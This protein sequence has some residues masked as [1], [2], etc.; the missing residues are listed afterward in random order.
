MPPGVMQSLRANPVARGWVKVLRLLVALIFM[1]TGWLKLGGHNIRD[2]FGAAHGI[3]PVMPLFNAMFAVRPYWWFLGAGQFAGGALLLVGRTALLGSLVCTPIVANIAVLI[4]ALPFALADRV[5]VALLV[6]IH[7]GLLVWEWP[8]LASV[9]AP[10]VED[11]SVTA[12]VTDAWARRWVRV[13][14]ALV[15]VAFVGAHLYVYVVSR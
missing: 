8:R 5:A 10:V 6:L 11:S 13:S 15:A 3:D 4:G 1:S 2:G 9:I 7:V 12:S 14:A